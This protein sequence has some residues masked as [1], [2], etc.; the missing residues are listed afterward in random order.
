MRAVGDRLVIT[1]DGRSREA[2]PINERAFLVD[3]HDPDNPTVTFG[4]FDA[5]GRPQILY[6]MLWGLPRI[7]EN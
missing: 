7:G 4:D 2:S 5:E 3:L 6:L 1:G